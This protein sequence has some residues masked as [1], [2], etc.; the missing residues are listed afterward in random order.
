MTMG[1]ASTMACIVEALGLGLPHNAALPAVDSRR[2]LLAH[3]VGRRAVEIVH[4]DFRLSQVLTLDAFRNAVRVTAAIG[5]STNA[6]LHLIAIAGRLGLPFGLAEWDEWGRNVPTLVDLMPSGRFLMEDF[7]YAGGIPAV[8][9][10]LDANGLLTGEAR[11]INGKTVRENSGESQ[12]YNDEVIRPWNRALADEGGLAVLRGNLA[13]RGA[14]LKPSAATPRLM[15][16]E[17]PALVFDSIE[18][19]KARIDDPD[20]P[21][22][23]DTVL[24]LRNCGPKGYPGMAEVGNLPIPRK[25]VEKGIRDMVRISDARMSGTAF[26]TVVL[27]V[28]PESVI[29]GPLAI[30]RDGDRIRL[31]VG[32]RRLDL[33]IADGELQTRLDAWTAP[34]PVKRSGYQGLYVER[35]LQADEGA[36]LDFLVGCRGAGIP[37][38]SH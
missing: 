12:V 16:H 9:R 6:V 20:L 13:P 37:R 38:E 35:V 34:E 2:K 22:E 10:L 4:E 5:G 7:C 26:G 8:Q 25:L 15:T 19:L 11:T 27:H 24:V 32:A 17:G 31:D 18:D 3:M 30:V 1:T 29:G 23:A 14:V 36:D 28:A 33:L 21:V